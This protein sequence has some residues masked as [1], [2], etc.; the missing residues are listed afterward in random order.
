M[1]VDWNNMLEAIAFYSPG[2]DSYF[3][4]R[5]FSRSHNYSH[6]EWGALS[7]SQE[8]QIKQMVWEQRRGPFSTYKVQ[9]GRW[10]KW[11]WIPH[12]PFL[13]A[14]PCWDDENWTTT[15]AAEAL[16]MSSD[17]N[18][19]L[20]Q[21]I[22]AGILPFFTNSATRLQKYMLYGMSVGYGPAR[23]VCY[24]ALET[25]GAGPQGVHRARFAS[26]RKT[27]QK[28]FALGIK[29][30]TKVSNSQH[31]SDVCKGTARFLTYYCIF[32]W[33]S[34]YWFGCKQEKMCKKTKHLG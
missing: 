17:K 27:V 21:R 10:L 3:Q 11:G 24:W 33:S 31:T 13:R 20:T 16:N 19:R 30:W 23:P 7:V 26:S 34:D 4:C 9:R 15:A 28:R 14:V 32:F 1:P 18:C 22:F 25:T 6:D 29:C 5:G 12:V 2:S 8:Q